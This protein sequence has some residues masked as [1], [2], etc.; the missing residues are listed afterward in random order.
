MT[1]S[2]IIQSTGSFK[3][4]YVS[5]R[6]Y[7]VH[8]IIFKDE[9]SIKS[10][11]VLE[12]TFNDLVAWIVPF[13]Y[14]LERSQQ[15]YF[16]SYIYLFINYDV[17]VDSTTPDDVFS[18]PLNQEPCW[19]L[20]SCKPLS[21]EVLIRYYPLHMEHRMIPMNQ[22][23]C[24]STEENKMILYDTSFISTAIIV[25]TYQK[26]LKSLRMAIDNY[27]YFK[28]NSNIMKLND[29][30]IK[31]SLWTSEHQNALF[32][33]LHFLPNEIISMI[34]KESMTY[35]YNYFIPLG[36]EDNYSSGINLSVMSR[37][38]FYFQFK[39][40]TDKRVDNSEKHKTD[41]WIKNKNTIRIMQGLIQVAFS[42]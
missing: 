25:S 41:I 26:E 2:I 40:F 12:I 14:L 32:E 19:R 11:D 4:P 33:S 30:E 34:E 16:G 1:E 18:M 20:V 6:E 8:A 13:W 31:Q 15:V 28:I 3:I 9:R 17:L 24:Y 5:D 42:S 29:M 35:Q 39:E 23:Q 10:I 21:F 38:D 22:Y 37:V 7:N 36:M 27:D